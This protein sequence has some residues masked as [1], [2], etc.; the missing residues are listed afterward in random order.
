MSQSRDPILPDGKRDLFDVIR[1]REKDER[2]RIATLELLARW[3]FPGLFKRLV[4]KIDPELLH[5]SAKELLL[6]LIREAAHEEL[7]QAAPAIFQPS[8]FNRSVGVLAEAAW[9]VMLERKKSG[10]GSKVFRLEA[11][12]ESPQQRE[13]EFKKFESLLRELAATE[14]KDQELSD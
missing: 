7:L 10:C 11:G 1:Q 6:P 13:R 9:Y 14:R 5:S 3:L 4:G 2:T 8:Q 12:A